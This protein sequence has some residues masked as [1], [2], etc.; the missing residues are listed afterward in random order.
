MKS[1]TTKG[2]KMEVWTSKEQETKLKQIGFNFPDKK[3]GDVFYNNE[4]V[5]YID[6]FTGLRFDKHDSKSAELVKS[7][8]SELK[9]CIWNPNND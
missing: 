3:S 8:E 2:N 9:L 4:V 6:N 1:L 5:G 7:L